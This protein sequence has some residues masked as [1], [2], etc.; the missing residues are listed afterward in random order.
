M[1]IQLQV[2]DVLCLYSQESLYLYLVMKWIPWQLN[3]FRIIEKNVL[4]VFLF[5]RWHYPGCSLNASGIMRIQ[6][7]RAL[8]S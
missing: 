6:H 4:F 1:Y 3:L 5:S 2:K 8:S 7:D